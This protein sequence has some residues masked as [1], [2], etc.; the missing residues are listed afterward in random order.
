MNPYVE[1]KIN[2]ETKLEGR[3]MSPGGVITL[4]FVARL[5]L[6]FVR[7]KPAHLNVA[8]EGDGV[9]LTPSAVPGP[10]AVRSS[11]RG[12][13]RLPPNAFH[14]LAPKGERRYRITVDAR[15]HEVHLAPAH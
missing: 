4:P 6:K 10:D 13:V 2:P 14:T 1:F 15:R 8:V 12:L 5:A 3:K 7:N 9:K 11:P